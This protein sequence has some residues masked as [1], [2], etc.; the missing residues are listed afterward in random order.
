M[1]QLNQR[2]GI[3]ND[4]YYAKRGGQGKDVWNGSVEMTAIKWQNIAPKSMSEL[5]FDFVCDLMEA[6]GSGY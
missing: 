2:I 5:K 4:I 1:P 6:K 3:L